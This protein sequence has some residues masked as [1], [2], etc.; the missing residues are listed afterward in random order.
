MV[1]RGRDR[2][3]DGAKV[4]GQR[5]RGS[6]SDRAQGSCKTGGE[7]DGLKE[8]RVVGQTEGAG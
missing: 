2:W 6:W 1:R 4:V 5:G 7:L 3:S 8:D